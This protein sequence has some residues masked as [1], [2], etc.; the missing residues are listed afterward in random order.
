MSQITTHILDT[1]RG[2]PAGGVSISMYEK[3]GTEWVEVA[4]GITDSDGRIK[5]LLKPGVILPMGTYKMK[6]ATKEYFKVHGLEAFYPCVE[7]IFDIRSQE[8]YHIPLLLN[9][10]GYSTYRGS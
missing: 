5:D 6:F 1:T 7:I 10:F 3:A 2:L 4:S 9:P 8:H